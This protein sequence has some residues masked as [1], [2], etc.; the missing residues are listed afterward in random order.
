MRISP[1]RIAATAV[2]ALSVLTPLSTGECGST[3]RN[4]CPKTTPANAGDI[5]AS[6][7]LERGKVTNR[8]HAEYKLQPPCTAGYYLQVYRNSTETTRWFKVSPELFKACAKGDR[9]A[10]S[11]ANLGYAWACT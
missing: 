5:G 6:G 8:F 10:K 9:I 4:G 1:R 11:G 3:D 2:L 7:D